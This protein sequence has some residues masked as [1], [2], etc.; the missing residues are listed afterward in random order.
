MRPEENPATEGGGGDGG[1]SPPEG[2]PQMGQGEQ[3]TDVPDETEMDLDQQEGLGN[4]LRTGMVQEPPVGLPPLARRRQFE[5]VSTMAQISLLA[6]ALGGFPADRRDPQTGQG[7]QQERQAAP[8]E[9]DARQA[10]PTGPTPQ[11]A[12]SQRS[13]SQDFIPLPFAQTQGGQDERELGELPFSREQMR[14]AGS[15]LQVRLHRSNTNRP[16]PRRVSMLPLPLSYQQRDKHGKWR[17]E[18]LRNWRQRWPVSVSWHRSWRSNTVIEGNRQPHYFQDPT[19]G[20]H[21]TKACNGWFATDGA[22]N[23]LSSGTEATATSSSTSSR[24]ATDSTAECKGNAA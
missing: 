18:G 13:D 4:E 20:G 24:T 23:L 3:G 8:Q 17:N 21:G 19:D 1:D 22:P 6:Q 14:Q 16:M 11:E 12:V 7:Q 2:G 10:S 5:I 15:L 9:E